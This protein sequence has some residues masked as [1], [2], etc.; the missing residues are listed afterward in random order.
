VKER[1][2][3][4]ALVYSG[5]YSGSILGLAL[6]PHMVEV[7]QYLLLKDPHLAPPTERQPLSEGVNLVVLPRSRTTP[8][9]SNPVLTDTSQHK[10]L[11]LPSPCFYHGPPPPLPFSAPAEIHTAPRC[12]L[13]HG[14]A[15]LRQP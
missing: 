14:A 4:L 8:G 9:N 6:S 12:Q 7:G 3:S 13:L 15:T 5:M 11:P 1:S 2:R 10:I